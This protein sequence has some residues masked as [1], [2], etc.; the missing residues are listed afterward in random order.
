MLAASRLPFAVSLLAT[1]AAATA[2]QAQC[3]QQRFA[4]MGAYQG[5][6]NQNSAAQMMAARMAA[7]QY[8]QSLNSY[9]P[10]LPTVDQL[11]QQ[12]YSSY[13][14]ESASCQPSR[15]E[16]KIAQMQQ[17]RDTEKTRRQTSRE[18]LPR[19]IQDNEHQAASKYELAHLLWQNGNA[20][21]AREWLAEILD[22]FP[23]TQT[24]DRARQTLARL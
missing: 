10:Q 24:A 21:A 4:Q 1:L 9:S 7:V 2:T 5:F 18:R 16:I 12:S 6:G 8:M 11:A 3:Q 13:G 19:P 17:R 22:K 15:N 20:P 23:S 14:Q